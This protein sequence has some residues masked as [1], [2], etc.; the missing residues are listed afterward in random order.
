MSV[1]VQDKRVPTPENR[2]SEVTAQVSLD[3]KGA[4]RVWL[5]VDDLPV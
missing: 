2:N 5:E 1:L 4:S 3:R